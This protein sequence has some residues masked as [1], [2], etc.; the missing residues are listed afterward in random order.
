[1]QSTQEWDRKQKKQKNDVMKTHGGIAHNQHN[2]SSCVNHLMW[3]FARN[4]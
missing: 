2:I 4:G 1:M 3:S